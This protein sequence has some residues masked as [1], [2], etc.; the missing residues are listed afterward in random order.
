MFNHTINLKKS[1]GIS[2]IEMMISM[3]LGLFLLGGLTSVYLGNKDTDKMRQEI[4]RME[5]NARMS[6]ASLSQGIA[7]AG[8]RSIHIIPFEMA[9]L[10]TSDGKPEDQNTTCKDNNDLLISSIT[11]PF[12]ADGTGSDSDQVTAVFLSDNPDDSVNVKSRAKVFVDCAGGEITEACSTDGDK[13][14]PTPTDAKIYNS[15]YVDS[16]KRLVCLGSRNPYGVAVTLAD[17]IE[18]MQIRY[19]VTTNNQTRYR[20]AT[21]IDAATEWQSVTSVQIALL[22]SSDKNI[23][24]TAISEPFVLL[25]QSVTVSDANKRKLHRV[26]SATVNLP[27]R[28]N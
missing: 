27:N 14:M 11:H 10:T 6:L 5:A 28:I 20:T 16:E 17:N 9:F 3:V 24:D 22:V 19:G 8:Y 15:Y 18:N 7:H 13:G 12:S 21:E 23:L 25:D 4:S 1:Y 2:L 26:Y